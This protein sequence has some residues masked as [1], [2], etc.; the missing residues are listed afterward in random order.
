MWYSHSPR[1]G[2]VRFSEKKPRTNQVVLCLFEDAT[3]ELLAFVDGRWVDQHDDAW[4]G[5][6]PLWWHP[7]P[8]PPPPIP[9]PGDEEEAVGA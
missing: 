7:L 4:S 5:G 1:T 3:K 9:F 2:W 8:E 6:D